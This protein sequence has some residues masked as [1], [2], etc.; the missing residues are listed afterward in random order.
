MA[1]IWFKLEVDGPIP[2]E[3]LHTTTSLILRPDT[4]MG[5]GEELLVCIQEKGMG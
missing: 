1:N 4:Y 3:T 2:Y 5:C